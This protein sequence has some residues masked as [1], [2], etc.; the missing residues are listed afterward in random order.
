MPHLLVRF[1]RQDA[2]ER[3]VKDF[4]ELIATAHRV[5]LDLL[6]GLLQAHHLLHIYRQVRY[7][8]AAGFFD[9]ADLGQVGRAILP[10]M[11]VFTVDVA[12]ELLLG[13]G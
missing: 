6:A 2:G 7:G 8:V 1:G 4:L 9:V 5:A 12:V 3:L 10:V 11:L 13:P